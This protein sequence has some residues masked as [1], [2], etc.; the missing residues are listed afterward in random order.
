[1]VKTKGAT[2]KHIKSINESEHGCTVAGKT[3]GLF[4]LHLLSD[5]NRLAAWD[6]IMSQVVGEAVNILSPDEDLKEMV[7]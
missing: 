7:L 5:T 3:V 4:P 1:V 6:E 2:D